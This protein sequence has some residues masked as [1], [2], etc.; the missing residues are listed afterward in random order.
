MICF[1]G[2]TDC[3]WDEN[4]KVKNTLKHAVSNS[5]C[6]ECFLNSYKFFF[7]DKTHSTKKEKRWILFSKTLEERV[8]VIVFTVR[9]K[10]FRVISARNASRKERKIY[11]KRIKST[12]IQK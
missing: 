5:E 12:K 11:E 6:E 8:L 10:K 4:N 3:D 7:S 9:G 1:S 2:I